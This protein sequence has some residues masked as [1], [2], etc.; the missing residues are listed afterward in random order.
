MSDAEKRTAS[1]SVRV[2]PNLKKRLERDAKSEKAKSTSEF[3][4]TLIEEALAARSDEKPPLAPAAAPMD[5]AMG[6]KLDEILRALEESE[7][8]TGS[9]LDRH[10]KERHGIAEEL[11]NL[12]RAVTLALV[13][14]LEQIGRVDPDKARAAVFAAMNP[15]PT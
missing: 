6:D 15:K 8:L 1:I 2:G 9:I 13:N 11:G 12:R 7:T 14:V 3:I 4:H 10:E 5:P